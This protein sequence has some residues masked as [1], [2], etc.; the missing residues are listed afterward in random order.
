M[1]SDGGRVRADTAKNENADTADARR[2]SQIILILSFL[3]QLEFV[4]S[5]HLPEGKATPP[6]IQKSLVFL[7]R[8]VAISPTANREIASSFHSSQ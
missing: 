2:F 3:A 6:E 4:G 1:K 8:A 7:N 5:S